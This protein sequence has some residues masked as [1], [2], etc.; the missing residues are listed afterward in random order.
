MLIAAAFAIHGI[1]IVLSVLE[2][3][4]DNGSLYPLFYAGIVTAVS[5]GLFMKKEVARRLSFAVLTAMGLWKT[6]TLLALLNAAPSG[7]SALLAE[8]LIHLMV[9]SICWFILTSDG[10]RLLGRQ[11]KA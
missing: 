11:E 8:T 6:A 4:F 10:A 5:I 7:K 2:R 9:L 1:G 3:G